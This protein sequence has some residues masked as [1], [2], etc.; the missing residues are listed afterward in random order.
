MTFLAGQPV[1]IPDD[2]EGTPWVM[3]AYGMIVDTGLTYD[4]L[5]DLGSRLQLAEGWKFPVKVLDRDL[6]ISAVDGK[7]EIVQDDLQNTYDACFDTA[8]TYRP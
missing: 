2:P 6:T 8:C 7:A 4:G 5:A 1:F 3:Q